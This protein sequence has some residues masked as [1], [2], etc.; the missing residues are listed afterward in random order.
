M[1]A[2]IKRYRQEE[3]CYE[4]YGQYGQK[5]QNGRGRKRVSE[6]N[7]KGWNGIVCGAC[8]KE[9]ISTRKGR[10]LGLEATCRAQLC[11]RLCVRGERPWHG[12]AAET[13]E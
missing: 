10:A 2:K 9:K 3:G 7:E 4:Q 12:Y 1:S 13:R 11:Q 6:E 5:G 8:T